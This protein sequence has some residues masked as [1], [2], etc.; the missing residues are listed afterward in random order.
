MN[1]DLYEWMWAGNFTRDEFIGL[2]NREPLCLGALVRRPHIVGWENGM[3]GVGLLTNG[4]RVAVQL[5]KGMGFRQEG[6]H[7]RHSRRLVYTLSENAVQVTAKGDA[8]RVGAH[9]VL[10][11]S[12]D[13]PLVCS[14]DGDPIILLDLDF[15]APGSRRPLAEASAAPHLATGGAPANTFIWD[16]EDRYRQTYAAGASTWETLT[17][18]LALDLFIEEF[19]DRLR[20]VIDLG[21]GEGRDAIYLALKGFE[22]T[23]VDVAPTG[24]KKAQELARKHGVG[25]IFLQRDAVYLRGFLPGTFDAAINMGCLHLVDTQEARDLHLQRVFD[26]LKPGGF[27]LVGHCR[28][29]WL[30]GFWSVVDY[31]D[32]KNRRAG[33]LIPTRLRGADGTAIQIMMPVLRHAVRTQSDLTLEL[34]TVG[35]RV[36][37]EY[38]RSNVADLG[39]LCVLVAQKPEAA[40]C[41]AY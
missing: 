31:E 22:V 5:L 3:S 21:T 18:N 12:S 32:A 33:E 7:P 19:G 24:L 38:S 6:E 37:K 26:V 39:N 23:G 41:S 10:E 15:T 13:L 35:L 9:E 27:F 25:P 2:I 20:S 34:E 16:F 11:F 29:H 30:K 8:I 17:P 36:I 4:P 14:R 1:E 28:Q 40:N